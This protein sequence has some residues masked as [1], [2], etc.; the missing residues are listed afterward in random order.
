M[1][2]YSYEIGDVSVLNVPFDHSVDSS[3]DRYIYRYIFFAQHKKEVAHTT[4]RGR[5][6][7]NTTHQTTN[8]YSMPTTRGSSSS[9]VSAVAISSSEQQEDP[10]MD[11]DPPTNEPI[12]VDEDMSQT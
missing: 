6:H 5:T 12:D 11:V 10:V 9:G 1:H 4:R 8:A 2:T 3:T 7:R